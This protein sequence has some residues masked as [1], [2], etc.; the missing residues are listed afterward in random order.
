M[1]LFLQGGSVVAVGGLFV[2]MAVD[3]VVSIVDKKVG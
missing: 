3:L 1:F 2:G